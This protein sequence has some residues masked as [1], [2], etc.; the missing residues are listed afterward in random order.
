MIRNPRR[1]I[2][3]NKR[4]FG[5]LAGLAL[6]I[7]LT[8]LIFLG[9]DTSNDTVTNI[10]MAAVNAA[11]STLDYTS[12]TFKGAEDQNTV[13]SDFTLPLNGERGTTISWQAAIPICFR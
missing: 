8:I 3:N 5:I 9:C 10:D 13:R 1:L 2:G 4:T 12:I 7:S 6:A 11:I